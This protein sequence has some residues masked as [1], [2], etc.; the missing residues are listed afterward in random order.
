MGRSALDRHLDRMLAARQARDAAERAIR[1][2]AN[3]RELEAAVR[4]LRQAQRTIVTG[5]P[6]PARRDADTGDQRPLPGR[7]GAR[8]RSGLACL[9]YPVAGRTR[10]RMHG[11][12]SPR[13][14]S[15]P[16]YRHGRARRSV[17]LTPSQQ[18]TLVPLLEHAVRTK[19][20]ADLL[21]WRNAYLA[22]TGVEPPGFP[23]R[24]TG[25]LAHEGA[26]SPADAPHATTPTAPTVCEPCASR[27]LPAPPPNAPS[28]R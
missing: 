10:C 20:A 18:R 7:C 4:A 25:T 22:T 5:A 12:A 17:R 14:V 16:H 21:A 23:A 28:D 8:T 9:A 6:E 19:K 1:E 26:A 3:P 24:Q 15:S 2:A 27:R 11:G 13:G